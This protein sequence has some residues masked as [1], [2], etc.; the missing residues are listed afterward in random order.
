MKTWLI[1]D[2]HFLH[3]NV[4]KFTNYDGTKT[5][6]WNSAAEGD[7]AMIDRWNSVVAPRDRLIHLGDVSMPRKGLKVLSQ[8]NG[9]KILIHGNHDVFKTKDFMEYFDEIVGTRKMGKFI[10]SHYPI[11][12]GSIPQWAH[13]NIHGHLHG[14]VVMRDVPNKWFPWKSKREPDPRYINVCVE[15]TNYTPIDFEEIVSRYE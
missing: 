5:R 8:L 4:Y 15:H 14:N 1:S 9:R 2:T 7:A 13:A 3:N 12:P 10:L 11:H 6:P